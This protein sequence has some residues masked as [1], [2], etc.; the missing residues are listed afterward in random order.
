MP[1]VEHILRVVLSLDILKAFDV[2]PKGLL[3]LDL[4]IYD[5]C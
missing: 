1:F 2:W 3:S 5:V 4:I